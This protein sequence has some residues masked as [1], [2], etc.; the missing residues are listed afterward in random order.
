MYSVYIPSAACASSVQSPLRCTPPSTFI[1]SFLPSPSHT[2]SAAISPNPPYR[3]T[4]FVHVPT[5][6]IR[7]RSPLT[8]SLCSF[9]LDLPCP[10]QF[11]ASFA[12]VLGPCALPTSHSVH[13]AFPTYPQSIPPGFVFSALRRLLPRRS[14][15]TLSKWG[16]QFTL[17]GARAQTAGPEGA[18]GVRG[19]CSMRPRANREKSRRDGD[20]IRDQIGSPECFW[21]LRPRMARRGDF[22]RIRGGMQICAPGK[23]GKVPRGRWR[24]SRAVTGAVGAA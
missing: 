21:V 1:I 11:S 15:H 12:S 2:P 22:G 20:L 23:R 19:A 6:Y 10:S 9:E 3:H 17:L 8:P 4:N 7:S 5:V 24:A 16:S 14:I 18:V 13:T